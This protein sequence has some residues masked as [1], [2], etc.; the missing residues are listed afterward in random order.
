MVM[1]LVGSRDASSR[2]NATKGRSLKNTRPMA[3][4]KNGTTAKLMI[5]VTICTLVS[6]PD[7]TFW[8]CRLII[9]G[10]TMRKVRGMMSDLKGAGLVNAPT[11]I[12]AT[13][14]AGIDQTRFL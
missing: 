10:Y 7:S 8:I 6:P 13:I 9:M 3:K 11:M 14:K 4:A 1:P 5:W 12:P 2:P